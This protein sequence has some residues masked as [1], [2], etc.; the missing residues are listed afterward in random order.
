MIQGI[1]LSGVTKSG[2]TSCIDTFIKSYLYNNIEYE[3]IYYSP[4]KNDKSNKKYFTNDVVI[5]KRISD[6]KIIVVIPYGDT[7]IQINKYLTIAKTELQRFQGS[8]NYNYVI[9]ISKKK[10]SSINVYQSVCNKIYWLATEK[11]K[12]IIDPEE[13]QFIFD[14][15]ALAIN[16]LLG[17][18]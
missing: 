10:D 18:I 1:I 15:M 8:T 11:S 3:R 14:C 17:K 7:E 13:R 6:D 4:Y 16:N 2:K 5:A 9:G 12:N